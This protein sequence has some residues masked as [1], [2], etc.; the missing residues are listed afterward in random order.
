MRWSSPLFRNLLEG[1]RMGIPSAAAQFSR[2]FRQAFSHVN[3]VLPYWPI[4]AWIPYG[5]LQSVRSGRMRIVDAVTVELVSEEPRK[6]RSLVGSKVVSWMLDSRSG[7]D[8]VAELE[9]RLLRTAWLGEESG[10]MLRFTLFVQ[11]TE[12]DGANVAVES[13]CLGEAGDSDRWTWPW[14]V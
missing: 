14:F 7:S 4:W 11:S 6:S 12:W 8:G 10:D 3:M 2:D 5:E 13:V 9:A 1:E